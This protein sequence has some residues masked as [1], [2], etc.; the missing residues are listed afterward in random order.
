MKHTRP[1]RLLLATGGLGQFYAGSNNNPH[2]SGDGYALALQAGAELADMEFVQFEPFTIRTN[3]V[4][5]FFG[6]SFLLG[7]D[8]KITNSLGENFLPGKAVNFGKDILS[9]EIFETDPRWKG[10]AVRGNLGLMLLMCLKKLSNSTDRFLK[11]CKRVGIDPYREPFEAGPSQHYMLGSVCIDLKS[12]STIPGL[13]AAGEVATGVHGAANR[14][15][16]SH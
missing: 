1:K 12:Q 5:D 6:I 8:P 3:R 15:Q 13:F 10:L 4:E 11:Y 16:L 14:R 9:R 2:L 7:D